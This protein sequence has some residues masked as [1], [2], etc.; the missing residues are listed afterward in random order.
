MREKDGLWAV[1]LWLN[2]LAARRASVSAIMSEHWAR[3]GRDYYTRHDFEGVDKAAAET[4]MAGLREALPTL[5]GR[6][7]SGLTVTAAD[8]FAYTD[9]VDGSTA[10]RQGVRVIFGDAARVVY[11]LSGTGTVGATLRVYMERFEPDP[12]PPGGRPGRGA[13]PGGRRSP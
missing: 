10:E 12:R 9:P 6:T 1:L 8:D 11:R 3:Y 13:R 2:V 5:P 7:L 4:L